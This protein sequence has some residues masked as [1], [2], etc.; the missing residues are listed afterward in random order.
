MDIMDL[1][2]IIVPIALAVLGALGT[3]GMT[4]MKRIHDR[5][6]KLEDKS[7]YHVTRKETRNLIDDKV[8]PIKQQIQSMDKK[9]DKI[10]DIMLER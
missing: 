1:F 10:I 5:L 3:I 4:M 8:V 7:E 9:L 6:Q 2:K